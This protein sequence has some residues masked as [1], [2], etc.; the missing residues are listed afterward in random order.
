MMHYY[1]NDVGHNHKYYCS[2]QR[3][4]EH[5]YFNVRTEKI[6]REDWNEMIKNDDHVS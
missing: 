1:H 3:Q 6:S 2:L 4:P 5:D